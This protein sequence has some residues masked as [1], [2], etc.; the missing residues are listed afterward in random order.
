MLQAGDPPP[1][2][3]PDRAG[4]PGRDRGLDA[5]A[6][7]SSERG[8]LEAFDATVAAIAARLEPAYGQA[9]GWLEQTRAGL[10]ELLRFCDERPDAARALVVESI[11]WGPEVLERRGQVLD[12]L[13]EGLDRGR[14][15]IAPGETVP[16][17]VAENL[18]GACVS[19]VHTR[20]LQQEHGS[21]MELAPSLMSMIAHPYLGPQAARRELE[22]SFAHAASH[23][24]PNGPG[25]VGAG[26]RER[27]Y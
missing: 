11:A 5:A 10:I 20:L 18:V 21:F 23:V 25:G 2:E 7:P 15:Q 27:S 12:A 8:R 19:L 13:A 17:A 24:S 22:R 16:P 26:V 3:A 14:A 9:D 6:G 4:R 1:R